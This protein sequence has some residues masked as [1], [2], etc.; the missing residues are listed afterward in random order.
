MAHGMHCNC[1]M[2]TVGKKLGIIKEE[3]HDYQELNNNG[4]NRNVCKHCGHSHKSDGRCACGC[5]Q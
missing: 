2:C 4:V 1:M 5:K 3:K